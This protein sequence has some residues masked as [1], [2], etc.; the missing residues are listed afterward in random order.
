MEWCQR[1][2]V[3]VPSK[4]FSR[5]RHQSP[6]PLLPGGGS[7]NEEGPFDAREPLNSARDSVDA[8]ESHPVPV[9]QL[10]CHAGCFRLVHEEALH[11]VEQFA[12]GLRRNMAS[13]TPL[14]VADGNDGSVPVARNVPRCKVAVVRLLAVAE[15]GMVCVSERQGQGFATD[16]V[17]PPRGPIAEGLKPRGLHTLFCGTWFEA[18]HRLE[19]G[20]RR[21]RSEVGKW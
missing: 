16:A 8:E 6:E 21:V 15:R 7:Q 18:T 9:R 2:A 17:R 20:M 4:G 5:R 19:Q 3:A 12:F 1:A 14:E 11:H 10:R 13:D